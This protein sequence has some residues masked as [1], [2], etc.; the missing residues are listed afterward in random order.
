MT[1]DQK[2]QIR[3]LRY[4]G[5]GY[6]KISN[7]IGVSRDSV[8]GYCKRN[9]L[10]GYASE[11]SLNH[12]QLMVDEFVYDF[13]LQCGAK[14]EQ[15]NKGRKRKFC[16]PKCKSEWERTNRKIYIFQCEH[17]EKEYKSLGNKNRKCCSH[18]CY[19]RNRFWRKEDAAQIVEK[20]LKR[21]K[22]EHIPK[23]L[24]ELL[25]SNLQE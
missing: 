10:D 4:K 17:R 7:I 9:G 2:K 8:R 15:S 12:Q 16:T 11:D 20:I 22:V 21:E 14:L 19:V 1:E 5:W 23:W 24:K 25:L 18:E 3:L 13:C 6:K